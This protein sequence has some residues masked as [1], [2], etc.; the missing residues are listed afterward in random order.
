MTAVIRSPI[1]LNS[2]GTAG[3]RPCREKEGGDLE[4]TP[5]GR[6]WL[7]QHNQNLDRADREVMLDCAFSLH[8]LPTHLVLCAV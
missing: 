3:L 6:R 8:L 4:S 1:N 7:T 2:K 5:G